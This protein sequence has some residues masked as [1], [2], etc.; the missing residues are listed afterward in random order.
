MEFRL[1][2]RYAI[3]GTLIAMILHAENMDEIRTYLDMVIEGGE[4]PA[5]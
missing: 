4:L 1:D 5:P 2:K 3:N